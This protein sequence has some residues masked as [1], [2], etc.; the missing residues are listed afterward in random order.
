MG[1]TCLPLVLASFIGIV[2][3]LRASADSCPDLSGRYVLQ[4]EDGRVL[5]TIRQDRC[6]KVTIK[7]GDDDVEHGLRL[8]GTFRRDIA[9]FGARDRSGGLERPVSRYGPV[10]VRQAA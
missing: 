4:G 5:V 6:G 1:V 9:W 3:N 7:W 10:V 2:A 8:D